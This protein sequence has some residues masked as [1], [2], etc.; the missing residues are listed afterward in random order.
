MACS[1]RAFCAAAAEWGDEDAGALEGDD[2]GAETAEA[3]VAD[4]ELK[5]A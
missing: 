5:A 1:N 4:G 2:R 3:R